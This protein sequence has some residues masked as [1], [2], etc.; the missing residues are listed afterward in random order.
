VA[1]A[2][3]LT[4]TTVVLVQE[5]LAKALLVVQ[6]LLLLGLAVEVVVPEA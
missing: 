3:A 6:V 2:V 1:Q 5:L 4:A